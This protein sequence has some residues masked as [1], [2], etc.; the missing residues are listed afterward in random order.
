M[1]DISGE[2]AVVTGAGRGVSAAIALAL[3]ERGAIVAGVAR[4]ALDLEGVLTSSRGLPGTFVPHAS[5]VTEWDQI[6][7]LASSLEKDFGTVTVLVNGAGTFG[8]IQ[9]VALSDPGEWVRTLLVS[10]AGPYLTT[11]RFL[12]GMLERGWGRIINVSSAASLHPP[13]PLNS[14]YGT[15]K[16][17]LNQFTRHV[18]SEIQ[19]TGVTAN[20]IHPGDLRT[21]MWQSIRDQAVALGPIGAPYLQWANWVEETGGDPPEKSASLVLSLIDEEPPRNGEFCW[22]DNP[23]QAPIPSWEQPRD[24]RPWA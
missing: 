15:A 17:A 6:D 22:I 7:R 10:V 2:V 16:V 11:R 20:V 4:T 5:D 9:Q 24:E 8:E 18:A 12:P 3:V 14:S 1:S 19:G 23:L 21:Q 13:G